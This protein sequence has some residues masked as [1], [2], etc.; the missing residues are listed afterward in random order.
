M[1]PHDRWM[2]EGARS[3]DDPASARFAR[4]FGRQLLPGYVLRG[5][6]FGRDADGGAD[7]RCE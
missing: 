7:F 4:G 2:S 5:E 3:P 6:I 1:A